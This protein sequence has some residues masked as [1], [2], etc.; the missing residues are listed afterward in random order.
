MGRIVR[1]DM[2]RAIVLFL[3]QVRVQ[4]WCT[5]YCFGRIHIMLIPLRL[6]FHYLPFPSSYQDVPVIREDTVEGK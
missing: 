5:S 4:V 1:C 3:V 6:P 2:A